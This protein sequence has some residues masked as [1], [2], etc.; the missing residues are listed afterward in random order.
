MTKKATIYIDSRLHRAAKIKAAES[1]R[2]LSELMAD[3]LKQSLHEDDL[4]LEAIRK[5]AGEPSRGLEAVLKDLR[6]DGLI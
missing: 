2:T 4:D 1:N 3:A 6:R 5:R